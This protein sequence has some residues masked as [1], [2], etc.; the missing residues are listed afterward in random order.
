M[1]IALIIINQIRHAIFL[2]SRNLL[3]LGL[4]N[5]VF[6]KYLY[7]FTYLH[8]FILLKLQCCERYG[9]S[10]TFYNGSKLGRCYQCNGKLLTPNISFNIHNF[11]LTESEPVYRLAP[12]IQTTNWSIS[13][14]L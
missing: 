11:N 4:N 7:M 13:C 10:C 3:V 1:I 9:I 5:F 14:N 2:Q 8:T 12:A 6:C